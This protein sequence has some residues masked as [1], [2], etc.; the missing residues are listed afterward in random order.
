MA[1][2]VRS[3]FLTPPEGGIAV[4]TRWTIRILRTLPIVLLLILGTPLGAQMDFRRGDVDGDGVLAVGDVVELV[5]QNFHAPPGSSPCEDAADV[6]DDGVIDIADIL[7]LLDHVFGPGRP[8]IPPPGPLVCGPDPTADTLTCTTYDC[9]PPPAPP[10]DPALELRFAVDDPIGLGVSGSVRVL[11]DNSSGPIDAWTIGVCHESGHLELVTV[12]E[13]SALAGPPAQQAIELGAGRFDVTAVFDVT[14]SAS[15]PPGADQE[16][17]LGTYSGVVTGPTTL[18][19]CDAPGAPTSFVRRY[20]ADDAGTVVPLQE[21]LILEVEPVFR[22]GDVTGDGA[23]S[24]LDPLYVAARQFLGGCF[25][26]PCENAA[27]AN[28]DGEVGTADLVGLLNQ[29]VAVP[30][31]TLPPPGTQC[32]PDPTPDGLGCA[33]YDCSPTPPPLDPTITLGHSDL[34]GELGGVARGTVW[35]QT[36]SLPVVA[37][38]FSICP[39]NATLSL[40]GSG[41]QPGADLLAIA[42][43][44]PDVFLV[45]ERADG[46][47]SSAVILDQFLGPTSLP[48][49]QTLELY[50]IDYD[51]VAPGIGTIDFCDVGPFPAEVA[52]R[53]STCALGTAIPQTMGGAVN[54]GPLFIRGDTNGDGGVDIQDL[55]HALNWY[56]PGLSAEGPPPQSCLPGCASLDSA[57]LNDNEYLTIADILLLAELLFCGSPI[58]PPSTCGV[59]PTSTTDGFDQTDPLY[60]VNAPV[61][62]FSGSPESGLLVDIELQAHSPTPVR[63]LAIAFEFAPVL[64]PLGTPGYFLPDPGLAFGGGDLL[65]ERLAGNEFYIGIARRCGTLLPGGPGWQPVGRIRF[66]LAPFAVFPPVEWIAEG[67][68]GGAIYRATIVDDQYRD[69]APVLTAGFEFARGNSNNLD[70]LVDIADP[71]YTLGY[72]FPNPPPGNSLSCFDAADANGDGKL[73]IADPIYTLAY[74]FSGGPPIPQPY[75]QCGF[76]DDIDA[77]DCDSAICP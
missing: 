12:E 17:Y 50:V 45:V 35:M 2:L 49:G 31:P 18:D 55:L 61:V 7:S 29:L 38:S 71:I 66:Q 25:Q 72:L 42:G 30:P 15:L 44:D 28:D 10:V 23:I 32:G 39:G 47:W 26:L 56:Y 64:A 41:V 37:W 68:A 13:G 57:D 16:L 51:V 58:S 36:G 14:G 24:I 20:S 73:D 60:A 1:R 70:A 48:P 19:Y 53:P 74:L 54:A 75:P 46:S 59:D 11:L 43:G 62:E 3:S 22:R 4:R 63:A 27:D 52:T 77:L 9:G 33:A 5:I 34:C 65:E 8:A 6:D 76:D 69:H 40:D 67:E 21:S